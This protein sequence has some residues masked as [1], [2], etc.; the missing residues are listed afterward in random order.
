[1]TNS[2]CQPVREAATR[3][4]LD[5]TFKGQVNAEWPTAARVISGM[6]WHGQQGMSEVGHA[7]ARE[8]ACVP[9]INIC[10][11]PRLRCTC[12]CPCTLPAFARSQNPG[13]T[14]SRPEYTSIRHITSQALQSNQQQAIHQASKQSISS[15]LRSP[16]QIR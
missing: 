12:C 3:W 8:C 2:N 16:P 11:P 5:S 15:D 6:A 13:P 9:K 1:M 14:L 10:T 7:L 4:A